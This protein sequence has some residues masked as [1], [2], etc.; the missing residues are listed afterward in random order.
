MEMTF[1]DLTFQMNE[2]C[3]SNKKGNKSCTTNNSLAN[4]VESNENTSR[5]NLGQQTLPNNASEQPSILIKGHILLQ[6]YAMSQMT[7]KTS[8]A[9][10]ATSKQRVTGEILSD[11]TSH[12][13]QTMTSADDNLKQEFAPISRPSF[14]LPTPSNIRTL[15]GRSYKMYISQ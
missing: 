8:E 3:R 4:I 9:K 13:H 6:D 10:S 11:L 7:D 14:L 15:F 5:E 2:I 12:I 1:D